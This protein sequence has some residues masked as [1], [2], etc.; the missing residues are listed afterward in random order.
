MTD[1]AVCRVPPSADDLPDE[2]YLPAAQDGLPAGYYRKLSST[3]TKTTVTLRPWHGPMPD[4]AG[5]QHKP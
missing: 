3:I 5:V 1:S 2:F 4:A